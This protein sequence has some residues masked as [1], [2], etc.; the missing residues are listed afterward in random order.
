[1]LVDEHAKGDTV[2]VEAVQK[3]LDVGADKRVE[4]KLL[5][6]LDHAL[7]HCRDDV[8]VS[9]SY[10]NKN[11]KEAMKTEFISEKYCFMNLYIVYI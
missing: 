2:C 4:A 6:I 3:V 9:V 10:V 11:L 1:M 7:G 8:V 5:L